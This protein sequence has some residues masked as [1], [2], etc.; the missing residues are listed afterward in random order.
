MLH[1]K[2]ILIPVIKG[3]GTSRDSRGVGGTSEGTGEDGSTGGGYVSQVDPSMS[4]AQGDENYYTTQD[5]DHGY[6]P[7]IWEQR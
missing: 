2:K 4:W 7:G 5:T 3:G 1:K 6:R